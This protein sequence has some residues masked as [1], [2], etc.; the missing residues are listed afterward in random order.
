[1][2]KYWLFIILFAGINNTIHAQKIINLS[3]YGVVSNSY[4]NASPA[5]A[6][7]IKDAKGADSCIIRFPGGRIDIWP[8]GAEQREYYISNATEDDSYI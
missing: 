4:K 1:M 3:D 7:A 2:K 6:Q 5:I 8:D